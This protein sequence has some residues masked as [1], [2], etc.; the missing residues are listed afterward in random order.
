MLLVCL[1]HFAGLPLRC[2]EHQA[3]R[4]DALTHLECAVE[5][6]LT[7]GDHVNVLGAVH[8]ICHP[9]GEPWRSC[10]AD[11]ATTP[12]PARAR[13]PVLLDTQSPIRDEREHHATTLSRANEANLT[14][15]QNS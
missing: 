4:P 5:R 14:L 9:D 1:T 2:G 11:S 13:Q 10:A 8:R 3:R 6:D 7:V 12:T 15:A